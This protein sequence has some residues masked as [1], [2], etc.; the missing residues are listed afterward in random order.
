MLQ[1]NHHEKNAYLI[2]AQLLIT[3]LLGQLN[4]SI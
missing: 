3:S 4:K 1:G 2:N